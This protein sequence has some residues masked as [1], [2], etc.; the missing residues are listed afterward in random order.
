MDQ[1]YGQCSTCNRYTLFSDYINRRCGT[2]VKLGIQIAYSEYHLNFKNNN[3]EPIKGYIN[4]NDDSDYCIQNQPFLRASYSPEN[5]K[6]E[7][8]KRYKHAW[9]SIIPTKHSYTQG[10]GHILS[11]RQ[12]EINCGTQYKN[13]NGHHFPIISLI[14]ETKD[15]V[16][17]TK[18]FYLGEVI[19]NKYYNT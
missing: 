4:M 9:Q 12:L 13:K 17:E 16:D 7:P 14:T 6:C 19:E 3:I 10:L 2:C 1:G 15:N 11:D 8:K 18:F 5:T